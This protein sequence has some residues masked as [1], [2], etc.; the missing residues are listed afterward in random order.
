MTI[1]SFGAILRFHCDGCDAIVE[2]EPKAKGAFRAAVEAVKERGWSNWKADGEWKHECPKC[3]KE[4]KDAR[5]ET[6]AS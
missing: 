2:F 6:I 4:A 5:S 3:K 1:T